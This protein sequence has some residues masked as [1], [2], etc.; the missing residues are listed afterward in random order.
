MLLSAQRVRSPDGRI[1]V[2]AFRFKHGA[3]I[4]GIDW[5]SMKPHEFER[6]FS[7]P[8]TLD[9]EIIEVAPGGNEVL[10]FIDVAGPDDL[11]SKPVVKALGSVWGLPSNGGVVGWGVVVHRRQAAGQ[12]R[13]GGL[14]HIALTNKLLDV[15]RLPANAEWRQRA[16][17]QLAM[18][19]WPAGTSWL[20][21]LTDGSA[22]R[23]RERMGI[24]WARPVIEASQ[25]VVEELKRLDSV[26]LGHALAAAAGVTPEFALEM[27]GIELHLDERV[28]RT[29]P[30]IAREGSGFGRCSQCGAVN[31]LTK[32]E[33]AVGLRC[34]FC[35][36]QLSASVVAPERR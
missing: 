11:G 5:T 34:R 6:L 10:A 36:T 21:Q 9:A 1:G 19:R 33:G 22:A 25:E 16:P 26:E 15:L 14:P 27:G 24:G 2:N 32:Q 35:G 8:A 28:L 29:W 31:A 13:D 18:T 7:L 4:S 12:P 17:L 30:D 20:L 23:V 3:S